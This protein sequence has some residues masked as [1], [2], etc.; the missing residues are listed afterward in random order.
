MN[1]LDTRENY[2]E[3]NYVRELEAGLRIKKVRNLKF[4]SYVAHLIGLRSVDEIESYTSN[5]I[6]RL[7]EHPGD[8]NLIDDALHDLNEAGIPIHEKA[9]TVEL[10]NCEKKARSE[11]PQN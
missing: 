10:Q 2:F 4:A 1:A 7:F 6:N 9:L 3:M 11:L 5:M 8:Q